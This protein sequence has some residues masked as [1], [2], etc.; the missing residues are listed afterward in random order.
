MKLTVQD[1]K[2]YI[3]RFVEQKEKEKKEME[4]KR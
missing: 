2:W 3:E 1:R 4:K